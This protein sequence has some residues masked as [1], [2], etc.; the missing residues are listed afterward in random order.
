MPRTQF[1]SALFISS[2]R[3][4]W[5]LQ[6]PMLLPCLACSCVSHG[7]SSCVIAIVLSGQCQR[8]CENSIFENN[9]RHNES[10]RRYAT[11]N[12]S[13]RLV[14]EFSCLSCIARL[15]TLWIHRIDCAILVWLTANCAQAILHDF[16][17]ADVLQWWGSK[18]CPH[19]AKYMSSANVNT[20]RVSH[21][22]E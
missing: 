8:C 13:S 19:D 7:Q 1:T 9:E 14:S 11:N 10:S 12:M 3:A 16:H 15:N 22:S 5:P 18:G 21:P 2:K 4:S 17:N 6:L 20:K